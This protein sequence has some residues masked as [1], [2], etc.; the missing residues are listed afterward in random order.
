MDVEAKQ[1]IIEEKTR[2]ESKNFL[3][4]FRGAGCRFRAL[5]SYCPDRED[6]VILYQTEPKGTGRDMDD[7]SMFLFLTFKPVDKHVILVYGT[8][9]QAVNDTICARFFK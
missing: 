1:R 6:V 4:L 5:H 3:L 9:P 8:G 2:S 7:D